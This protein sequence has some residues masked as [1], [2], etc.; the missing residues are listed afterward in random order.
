MRRVGVL[1]PAAPDDAEWQSWLGAFLQGLRAIGLVHR[2]QH[3]H[4]KSL[5]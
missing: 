2:T 1:L 3:T 4:R 5:D